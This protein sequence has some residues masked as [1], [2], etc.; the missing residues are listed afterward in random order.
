MSQLQ[1]LHNSLCAK[2]NLNHKASG[3]FLI[4]Q[5]NC[6]HTS[7]PFRHRGRVC[8]WNPKVTMGV[9]NSWLMATTYLLLA[10]LLLVECHTSTL[11]LCTNANHQGKC[12]GWSSFGSSGNVSLESFSCKSRV[13]SLPLDAS[14]SSF[15]TLY[16]YCNVIAD[17]WSAGQA[18]TVEFGQL[19]PQL[20]IGNVEICGG[21]NNS[22]SGP[23]THKNTSTWLAQA[24]Y[25]W[26]TSSGAAKCIGGNII[27]A[28]PGEMVEMSIN[29]LQ[30]GSI[31]VSIAVGG[32][33]PSVL[34]VPHPQ[35]NDTFAWTHYW[36]GG[37]LRPYASYEA[38]DAPANYSESYSPGIWAVELNVS[39]NSTPISFV[40]SPLWP[41]GTG[42]VVTKTSSMSA[43]WTWGPSS[44]NASYTPLTKCVTGSQPSSG[45]ILSA[46]GL[47]I[48]FCNNTA[49][50]FRSLTL[51]D[52]ASPVLTATG[53]AQTVSNV[54]VPANESEAKWPPLQ[55]IHPGCPVI[56]RGPSGFLGTGHGGEYVFSLILHSGQQEIDLLRNST[57]P[58]ARSWNDLKNIS[59]VKKSQIGPFLAT[60]EVSI[61]PGGDRMQGRMRVTI[62]LTVAYDDVADTVNYLYIA[63]SMFA[64]HFKEWWAVCANGTIAR[65]KFS[66]DNAFTLQRDIRWLAVYDDSTKRGA[67]YQYPNHRAYA[68]KGHFKNSFW[69]REFDHKL[70]LQIDPPRVTGDSA[71]YVH[72]IVP[73]VVTNASENWTQ[74]A[75]GLVHGW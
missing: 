36:R 54:R 57:L 41:L 71:F 63:M 26:E 38:W 44:V 11:P 17:S 43:E 31:F 33:T 30:N 12:H 52:S 34:V 60:E 2:K 32:R 25:F 55:P 45:F 53:F 67:M 14:L 4:G 8:H 24:Q 70:Y 27:D 50:T 62:N 19:V 28:V 68:G 16:L 51:A 48:S 40:G 75:R 47:N 46:A 37:K 35:L 3:V 10:Q 7:H 21:G 15:S 65:G 56:P 6:S 69:N 39:G 1:I 74:V 23:H 13:P 72:E 9:T 49:W 59:I 29:L 61:H 22:A 66:N 58:P 20:M 18:A 5:H 42:M 73:F 64:E